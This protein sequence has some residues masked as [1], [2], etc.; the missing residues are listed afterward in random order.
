MERLLLPLLNE[1]L[2]VPDFHHGFRKDHST[3]TAF[4]DFNEAVASGFNK[5]APPD[6][7]ILVQLDLSKAFDMVSLWR[8]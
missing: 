1:H 6:R 2:T 5:E 3:V 8:S 7:T 4:D